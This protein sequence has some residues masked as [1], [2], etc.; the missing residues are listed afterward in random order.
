MIVKIAFF[1]TLLIISTLAFLPDYSE[2]PPVVSFSDKL[3]HT[4]AFSVLFLLYRFSFTHA[5]QR[6]V[7]SLLF[8]AIFIE[9]VQS[10][11]P[12]RE[13][14]IEDVFADSIGLILGIVLHKYIERIRPEYTERMKIN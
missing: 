14:S 3:N 8:Y 6:I 1:L 10:F 11:L 12:T 9:V 7:I 2:L 4:A 5:I 13:A